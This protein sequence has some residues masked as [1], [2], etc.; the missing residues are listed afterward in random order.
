MVYGAP[1]FIMAVFLVASR[2]QFQGVIV[3]LSVLWVTSDDQLAIV[4]MFSVISLLYGRFRSA[5]ES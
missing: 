3:M 4:F 5:A 1:L 2:A